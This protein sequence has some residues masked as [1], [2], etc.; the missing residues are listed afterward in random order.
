MGICHFLQ[1]IRKVEILKLTKKPKPIKMYFS[2]CAHMQILAY[3][4][5]CVNSCM[6]A[7]KE[8][9]EGCTHV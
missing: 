5:M 8:E 4:W 6:C 9:R 3:V 1:S 2:H 7:Q